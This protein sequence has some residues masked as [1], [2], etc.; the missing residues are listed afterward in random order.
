MGET[1]KII[2]DHTIGLEV[3]RDV[4]FN[5]IMSLQSLRLGLF[6]LATHVWKLEEPI[7]NEEAKRQ[8]RVFF[9]GNV[10]GTDRTHNLLLPCYFHWFGVS[11]CNYV[12]LVGFV[13]G[14][15]TARITR[16]HLQDTKGFKRI[17]KECTTYT[18]TVPEIQEVVIWRNKVG[19]HFAITD[20]REEDNIATLD[21]SV[22]YPV[23][24]FNG[25][26]R[27]NSMTF[28]RTSAD[29]Q[30]HTAELPSWSITEVWEELATRYWPEFTYRDSFTSPPP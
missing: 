12:R 18:N 17:K 6:Q 11:L 7:R 5:E 26:F 15:A 29:G 25:R 1:E 3:A 24:F 20:P 23:S 13:R 8:E 10:P 21:M 14:L 19:A 28:S 9:Y 16:A 30:S 27:V 2:L 22:I 4:C